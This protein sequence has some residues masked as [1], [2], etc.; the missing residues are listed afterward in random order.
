MNCYRMVEAYVIHRNDVGGPA[1]WISKLAPWDHVF[2]D[3][4][5][6]TQEMLGDAAAVCHSFA[7]ILLL[8]S[9]LTSLLDLPDIRRMG[10][11]LEG[12]RC[13]WRPPHRQF[14]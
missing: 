12:H 14:E 8:A 1:A 7:S 4:L 9:H 11:Q 13:A 10:T 2:K 6:A 3:T 5:Y